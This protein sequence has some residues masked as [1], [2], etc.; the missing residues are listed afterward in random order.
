VLAGNLN[1]R[2][3]GGLNEVHTLPD[4]Q[5][6]AP[7]L[8]EAFQHTYVWAIVLIAAA[9][10]PALLISRRKPEVVAADEPKVLVEV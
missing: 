6:V 9:V 3:D 1:D 8:A 7:Q 4:P 5:S 2:V 10:L